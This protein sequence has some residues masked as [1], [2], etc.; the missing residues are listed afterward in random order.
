M[1]HLDDKFDGIVRQKVEEAEFAFDESNWQKAS[2][3]ID[4]DRAVSAGRGGKL[5]LLFGILTL[6]FGTAGFFGY[7]YFGSN[8][9]KEVSQNEEVSSQT[10]SVSDI[11]N[12]S[13]NQNTSSNSSAQNLNNT[14]TNLSSD[15]NEA[16]ATN[17]NVTHA[18]NSTL[19]NKSTD[20][21]VANASTPNNVNA[22]S[23]S[24]NLSNNTTGSK[25]VNSKVNVNAGSKNPVTNVT[26]TSGNSDVA[27]SGAKNP[28]VTSSNSSNT[29]AVPAGVDKNVNSTTPTGTEEMPSSDYRTSNLSELLQKLPSKEISLPVKALDS[30]IRKTPYDFIRI[31]D[32][33]YYKRSKRK[34]HYANFELGTTYLMGWDAANG[35]DGQGFNAFAGFNFGVY[36]G[37]RASVNT[38]IQVYNVGNIKQ[39]FYTASKVTYGFGSTGTYTNVTTNNLYYFA[40]PLKFNYHIDKVNQV[41][42]GINAGFLF[43]G[44]STVETYKILDNVK[45]DVHKNTQKGFYDGLNTENF[46][47]CASY[48]RALNKRFKLNAEV[49][50]GLSDL[51]IDTPTSKGKQNNVGGK[52]SIQYNIFEK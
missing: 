6:T 50:Y 30:A 3:L 22:K 48:S 1:N 4:A 37:K 7:K 29:N 40:V 13:S 44:K 42:F 31:Y 21:V 43:N 38:G 23:S 39:S 47:L 33:D 15:N 51:Y 24:G 16:N 46:T 36:C 10:V 9:E 27:N 5:F 35:R 26:K 12:N 45:T 2:K 8:N 49:I 28:D 52:L 25:A 18:D 34:S 11:Q 14:A 20:K 19:E 17:N 41:G 32:N